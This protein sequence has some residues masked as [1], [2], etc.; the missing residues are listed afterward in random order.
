MIYINLGFVVVSTYL[1][2][3]AE[4]RFGIVINTVAVMLNLLAVVIHLLIK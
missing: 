1:A 4:S 2:A 3:T